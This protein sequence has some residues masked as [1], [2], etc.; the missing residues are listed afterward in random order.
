MSSEGAVSEGSLRCR[1]TFAVFSD[2]TNHLSRCQPKPDGVLAGDATTGVT[3]QVYYLLA[4]RAQ[5]VSCARQL[6]WLRAFLAV[7]RS[8][9]RQAEPFRCTLMFVIDT[10]DIELGE[11]LW[12]IPPEVLD[13]WEEWPFSVSVLFE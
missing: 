7:N 6:E 2:A 1:A 8:L 10:E 13:L 5:S 11:S 3:G 4:D 9:I 12:A